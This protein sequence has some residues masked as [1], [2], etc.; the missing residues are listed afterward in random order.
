MNSVAEVLAPE[1]PTSTDAEQQGTAA[2][3]DFKK[4]MMQRAQLVNA[5]LD[6]AVPRQYP[7]LINDAMRWAA[8]S[9]EIPRPQPFVS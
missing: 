2:G 1:Q 9:T 4:Y 6:A 3:F 5:A 7:H 8:G